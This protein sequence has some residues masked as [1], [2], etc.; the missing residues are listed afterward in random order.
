MAKPSVLISG[1]NNVA[2]DAS[3]YIEKVEPFV[4]L[5][6]AEKARLDAEATAA[7]EEYNKPENVQARKI[8]EAKDMSTQILNTY[9]CVNLLKTADFT[10]EEY[11]VF[12]TAEMYPKWEPNVDY[13]ANDRILHEGVIYKVV[14]PVHSIENQAPNAEGMLAIY[15]PLSTGTVSEESV[16]TKEDPIT[17]ISG[18]EVFENKYY[19]Y[20][21]KLWLCNAYMNPCI[22][23][24][25][26]VG[27]W[28][29]TEVK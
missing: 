3:D 13:K 29:W 4:T 14:Q 17:F 8:A 18:M 2:L 22:W 19:T 12:A 5:W 11:N 23:T 15:S 1:Q 6:E 10:T 27:L 7:E 21:N 26:T 20:A 9:S 24:P 25:G 28:Q 16:G